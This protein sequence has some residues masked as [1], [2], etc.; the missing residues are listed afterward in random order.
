[1]NTITR[2]I[3]LCGVLLSPIFAGDWGMPNYFDISTYAIDDYTSISKLS[4]SKADANRFVQQMQSRVNA[5]GVSS[6][7][8]L[9]RE[10]AN[11]TLANFLSDNTDYAEALLF[12][13]HGYYAG[14]WFYPGTFYSVTSLKKSFSGYTKWVFFNSC[15]TLNT[16]NANLGS[17]FNGNHSIMGH[18]ADTWEFIHAYGC[19]PWGCSR[20]ERSEDLWDTF[21]VNWVTNG[22]TIWDAWQNAYNAQIAGEG[23]GGQP[24]IAYKTGYIGTTWFDGSQEKFN[25]SYRQ[26]VPTTFTTN[27]IYSTFGTPQY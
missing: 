9:K 4:R 15:L 21:A 26:A 13:G 22:M 16:S 8:Y 6:S 11:A 25:N 23:L 1:M 18:H 20:H 2:L 10:D 24:A 5:K 7:W 12:R 27:S 19:A 14:L 3:L 17:W